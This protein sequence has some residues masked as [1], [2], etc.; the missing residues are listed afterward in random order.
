MESYYQSEST[1][2]DSRY[3][4]TMSCTLACGFDPYFTSP[5]FIFLPTSLYL[6]LLYHS[7]PEGPPNMKCCL[8][9][10]KLQMLNCSI[11]HKVAHQ[12]KRSTLPHRPA[13]NTTG[14][15]LSPPR[16]HTHNSTSTSTIAAS[17]GLVG[18]EWKSHVSRGVVGNVQPTAE[19]G[20]GK[21]VGEEERDPVSNVVSS[22]DDCVSSSDE[23]E[24]FEALEDHK[25]NNGRELH[26]HVS[27]EET[28][29][30]S[31]ARVE[32]S[33]LERVGEAKEDEDRIVSTSVVG[34][35]ITRENACVPGDSVPG[36]SVH[37]DS[38]PGD[39]V[40]GDSG[41]ISEVGGAM[42]RLRL[43]GDLVLVA[44]GDPM[45]IPVTQ[46]NQGLMHYLL[47]GYIMSLSCGGGCVSIGPR[48]PDRGPCVGAAGGD[49]TA[50]Y[51]GGGR[52]TQSQDA[53]LF[54]HV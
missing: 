42:G 18:N 19:L 4:C 52:E 48:P 16:T 51:L 49:G 8:L 50:G 24:F 45:Y 17:A 5:P 6:F 39:S 10:Q 54:S 23:D 44:T 46:V 26:V 38:V 53:E 13:S 15:S 29:S 21:D 35:S 3:A 32:Q 11:R 14:P 33:K 43:C 47:G 1:V 7:I 41:D 9:H 25:D 34:R 30:M 2:T 12:H 27:V 22:T 36:E 28:A 31:H 20:S 40:P 37:G